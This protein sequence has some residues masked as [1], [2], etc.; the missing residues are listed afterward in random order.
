VIG[1]EAIDHA[2]AASRRMSAQGRTLRR[3][4]RQ[5]AAVIG[6]EAIDH[7]GAASRRLS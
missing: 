7:A 3:H 2:G 4:G 1:S 5:A 6:S